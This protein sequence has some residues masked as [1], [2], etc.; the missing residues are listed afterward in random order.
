MA[1]FFSLQDGNLSN[2]SIYGYSLS[3]AEV[4]SNTTG[5]WLS[6]VDAYGPTFTGDGSS[7]SAVAVHL[8]ARSADPNNSIL[9]L[10]LSSASSVRTETYPVSSF[11]SYNGSYNLLTNNNKFNIH[12]IILRIY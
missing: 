10:K 2:S 7:I 3:S 1:T 9:T 4:M 5:V 11:T 6:T 12:P 8:S